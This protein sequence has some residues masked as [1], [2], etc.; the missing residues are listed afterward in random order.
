MA[1]DARLVGRMYRR[2]D[3]AMMV[4]VRPGR[5][6]NEQMAANLGLKNKAP[7]SLSREERAGNRERRQLRTPKGQG[8]A[9]R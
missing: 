3:G 4:E 1:K 2:D 8:L 6:I 9:K 7:L 5:F